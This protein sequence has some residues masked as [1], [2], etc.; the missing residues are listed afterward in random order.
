MIVETLFDCPND[1]SQTSQ[2]DSECEDWKLE[3]SEEQ[4][5]RFVSCVDCS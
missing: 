5:V 3:L 2:S 1:G 4:K